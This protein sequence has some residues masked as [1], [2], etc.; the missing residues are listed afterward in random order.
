[1]SRHCFRE[2]HEPCAVREVG[3]CASA[4]HVPSL[5][6]PVPCSHARF[7]S[8]TESSR[9]PES[10]RM[11]PL[12][13]LSSDQILGE[14]NP[15]LSRTVHE[16][17]TIYLAETLPRRIIR[18]PHHHVSCP[19]EWNHT[20]SQALTQRIFLK[21]TRTICRRKTLIRDNARVSGTPST[22]LLTSQQKVSATEKRFLH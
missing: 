3:S 19:R 12:E 4:R 9:T 14:F 17:P 10:E 2:T 13:I 11:Q 7:H 21:S 20:T 8:K 22:S 5:Y 16:S 1:M 18:C 6:G 15:T